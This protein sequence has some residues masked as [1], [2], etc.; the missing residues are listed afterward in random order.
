MTTLARFFEQL[1]PD[2][3]REVRSYAEFLL[4]KRFK[5]RQKVPSFD[6]EGALK[7]I[8]EQYSSVELQHEI[9]KMRGA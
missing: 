2:I 9:E 4:D 8:G 5:K 6:W 1:P 3:Q 7:D